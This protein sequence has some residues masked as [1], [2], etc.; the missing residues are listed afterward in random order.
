MTACDQFKPTVLEGQ[1]CYSLDIAKM[2]EK[3]TKSGKSNGLFLL[4]DP[5]PNPKP[6]APQESFVRS[7]RGEQPFKVFIHTLAQYTTLG[8]GSYGMSALKSMTGTESFK[9]LPDYQKKCNIHNREECQTQ[10]YKDHIQRECNCTPWALK[11]D[12]DML[13]KGFT[14]CGPEKEDCVGKQ[15]L[16]DQSCLIPCT[17][18]YADIE[19]DSLKQT[20]EAFEQNMMKGGMSM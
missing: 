5:N 11:T 4:L 1:L 20:V 6:H 18:L 17:G 2:R 9:Q 19:D 16:K 12:Q 7:K 10:K 14:S 3:P 15:T 8:P 13:L